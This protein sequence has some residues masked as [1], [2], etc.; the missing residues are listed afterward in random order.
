[1]ATPQCSTRN[2]LKVTFEPDITEWGVERYAVRARAASTRL[3][4]VLD[5]RRHY[6]MEPGQSRG[7]W[8]LDDVVLIEQPEVNVRFDL[9]L[10]SLVENGIFLFTRP[11]E[12]PLGRLIEQEYQ[13]PVSPTRTAWTGRPF[14][15]EKLVEFD[16]F[17]LRGQ[18][19]SLCLG[20]YHTR[21]ARDVV[22]RLAGGAVVGPLGAKI[23]IESLEFMPGY[24]GPGASRYMP[25][26]NSGPDVEPV[27]LEGND[28][29]R[30]F[31]LTFRVPTDA[32]PGRYIG[33]VEVMLGRNTLFRRIPVVLRVQDLVQ[34]EIRDLYVGLIYNGGLPD[35][36]GMLR[37][38]ARSGFT[39]IMW[40]HGFIPYRRGD[41]G[42]M[43][44]DGQALESKMKQLVDLGITAGCGLYTDVQLDDRPKGHQ[45]RMIRIA[46]EEAA[47]APEGQR[48]SVEKAAYGRLLKELDALTKG[49]PEWPAILHMNWDEPPPFSERMGWTNEILPKAVTTLDVQFA[50]LPKILPYYNTP[51]FDDPANW[52]GPELY[53]YMRNIGK[54]FGLCGAADT[55]EANRYQAGLFMVASGAKYFHAWHIRG[56]HTPGQM[57]YDERRGRV[58][59]GHE[60]ISWANGMD[61]L[62]AYRLV[63]D[64]IE[65]SHRTGRNSTAS[66]VAEDYLASVLAVFNGDHK[67]HWSLQPYLGSASSW[68]YERFYDDWQEQMAKHAARIRNVEW[69]N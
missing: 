16:R 52:A 30:Y 42:R 61:D 26:L 48:E 68:G 5:Q 32:K 27:T 35:V 66:R 59:R 12:T 43:H 21:E 31:F 50:R 37:Q 39:Q 11:V 25:V 40:F 69:V 19:V 24:S 20:A 63:R 44:I 67:D 9:A 13:K 28:G 47:T 14:V 45:G 8:W 1:M 36:D 41:D 18:R 34:P 56:G 38:Y 17:A 49:H 54:D 29:V 55:G 65:E 51:N 23:P 57:A 7:T 46:R 3:A 33:A 60:M 4:F 15:H 22:V 6:Y 58:I 64:A 62:K 2:W 10:Q 53:R